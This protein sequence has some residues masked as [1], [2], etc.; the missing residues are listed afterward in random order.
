MLT[1]LLQRT[2][3][4]APE[5]L[6][7]YL[8][9]D[10]MIID[11]LKD[12]LSTSVVTIFLL[13]IGVFLFKKAISERLKSA[14][15]HEYDTELKKLDDEL[16]RHTEIELSKLNNRLS[17]ELELMK[18]KLGPY[19]EKQFDIYNKLWRSLC[20]L[21]YSMLQLWEGTSKQNFNVFSAKLEETT[22]K[23]EKSA[24]VIEKEHYIE[25]M[26]ILNGFANYEM[27][28]RTLIEHRRD[29]TSTPYDDDI[30]NMIKNNR[31][32]KERLLKYLPQMM[33]L[34]RDQIS[35]KNTEQ[36]H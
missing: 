18:M 27:G 30:R 28:K 29:P 16:K 6:V 5:Q 1:I 35:G 17:V 21:K 14:V 32:T 20:D 23:L 26:N 11:F 13:S 19:S 8:T 3:T 34:L 25:L 10:T 15:K 33:N 31:T 9:E 2:A 12:V 7:R 24:L 4:A 36:R 22:T